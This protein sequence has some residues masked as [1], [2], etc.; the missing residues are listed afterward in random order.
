MS[1]NKLHL[2]DL[3]YARAQRLAEELSVSVEEIVSQAI[4]RFVGSATDAP[5]ANQTEADASSPTNL[6]QMLA[7]VLDAADRLAATAA[8][9]GDRPAVVPWTDGLVEKL[10][11]QGFRL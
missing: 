10:R 1:T 9:E 7:G 4:E 6:G 5:G 8:G 2:D 11:D 3:T